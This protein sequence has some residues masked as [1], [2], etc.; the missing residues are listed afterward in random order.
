VNSEGGGLYFCRCEP[1]A[2]G[3]NCTHCESGRTREVGAAAIFFLLTTP[4]ALGRLRF[5]VINNCFRPLEER[6]GA[7]SHWMETATSLVETA[8][9]EVLFVNQ[10]GCTYVARGCI[11][12][13][14][15]E[16]RNCGV[17]FKPGSNNG[18]VIVEKCVFYGAP[19]IASSERVTI[20]DPVIEYPA[21]PTCY[22][23][24]PAEGSCAFTAP[25]ATAPPLSLDCTSFESGVME[26]Q[27]LGDGDF[28]YTECIWANHYETG[29]GGAV[30]VGNSAGHAARF[31]SCAWQN[32]T[33]R[34]RGG[35]CH[36]LSA[37]RVEI[38]RSCFISCRTQL[39][40]GACSIGDEAGGDRP[41]W[42]GVL[43]EGASCF[44][45]SAEHQ[46]GGFLWRCEPPRQ[47]GVNF[48]ACHI[49]PVVRR[50]C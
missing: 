7:I 25:C 22:A 10:R 8:M 49:P 35:A 31:A 26:R 44:D 32:C 16:F 19:A 33:A 42:Q 27:V 4:T 15:C 14:H 24:E 37:K 43:V 28:C 21:L 3:C 41:I 29:A 46:G 11:R 6:F 36:W 39:A 18:W 50:A 12:L 45:C 30:Y 2:I 13:V 23:L 40:G 47:V 20:V 17:Y 38:L 1:R 5:L 48:T 9:G 34:D